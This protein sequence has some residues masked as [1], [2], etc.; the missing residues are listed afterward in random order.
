MRVDSFELVEGSGVGVVMDRTTVVWPV[1][2]RILVV[3]LELEV[4]VELELKLELE[5]GVGVVFGLGL[6]LGLEY[7]LE[8]E[9]AAVVDKLPLLPIPV[10]DGATPASLTP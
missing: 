2:E 9:S 1:V 7:K 3:E 10:D 8:L 5:L 4:E 6:G